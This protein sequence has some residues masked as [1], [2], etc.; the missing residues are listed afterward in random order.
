MEEIKEF[1]YRWV[2]MIALCVA[3][4]GVQFCVFIAAGCAGKL[5]SPDYGLDP[6]QFGMVSTMPYLIGFLGGIAFGAFA[7]RTSIRLAIIVGLVLSLL[8]AAIRIFVTH[9]FPGLLIT[10]LMVGF[11]LA[12]TNANSAK[13]FKIWFPKKGAP[14]AMGVYTT[15]ASVGAAAA[16]RV[17]AM[18]DVET[19]MII[20]CVF[21][22]VSTVV[23]IILG[24]TNQYEAISREPFTQY[25]KASLK[26]KYVWIVSLFMFFLFGCSVTEQTY[27]NA[28][29]TELLQGD[30][31]TASIIAMT[32]SLCVA[33]GGIIMPL[34]VQRMKRLKPIMVIV[35]VLMCINMCMVLWMPYSWFTWVRMILQG[36]Y[37]GTLLPMG[38]MLPALMPGI[39]DEHLGAAGGVQS[40]FQNLG[41]WLLPAYVLAPIVMAASGGSFLAFY[42]GAG[43][44]VLL[45]GLSMFLIPEC[46]TNIE[47]ARKRAAELNAE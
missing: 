3:L 2:M 19:S 40:S 38:K 47:A 37:M 10:S 27:I 44:C 26:N 33:A 15:G 12:A 41:A 23:W 31:D 7:D 17:G 4:M 8:G 29:F 16:L 34:I 6:M 39:K 18:M 24:K 32:N 11:G 25:L 14:I 21:C 9:S 45:A 20:G 43:I 30:F 46:G 36:I 22:A 13:V 42:I 5:M 28:A 1:R 35:A